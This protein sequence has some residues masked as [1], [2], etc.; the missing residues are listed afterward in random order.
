[1]HSPLIPDVA[2]LEKK[3]ARLPVKAYQAGETIL[4]AASTSGQ[5]FILKEGMVQ[6]VKDGVEIAIV[7]EPGAIFGELSILLDLPHT[8]DVRAV[9]T[10]Q[11]NVADAETLLRLEPVALLYV[12]TVLARRLDGAN[13]TLIGL[14]R[15]LESGAP[16][17]VIGKTVQTMEG[18]LGTGGA[19][20]AYAGY[21]FDPFSSNGL[22]S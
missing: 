18:L 9:E 3:L 5:L 12:A 22:R 16:S 20:L 11:F 15:Q 13:R 14:K 1:M 19:N 4:S 6:V 17:S 7:T 8:A 2:E 10:S 21:P